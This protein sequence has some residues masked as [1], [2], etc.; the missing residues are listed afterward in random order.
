MHEHKNASR[1]LVFCFS[2]FFP[3]AAAAATRN[4]QSQQLLFLALDS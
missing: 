2:R 1:V 3:E 4:Y